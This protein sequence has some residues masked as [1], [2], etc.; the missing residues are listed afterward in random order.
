MKTERELVVEMFWLERM[1]VGSHDAPGQYIGW[2]PERLRASCE[3]QLSVIHRQLVVGRCRGVM[4]KSVIRGILGQV[5]LT[6]SFDAVNWLQV[7]LQNGIVAPNPKALEYRRGRV[8]F[9]F[10]QFVRSKA[11]VTDVL[12]NE[13]YW[14][15]GSSFDDLDGEVEA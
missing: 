13:L 3:K 15:L 4:S 10:V 1:R 2:T 8:G 14:L 12:V 6:S 9:L 11:P 5:R 7:E